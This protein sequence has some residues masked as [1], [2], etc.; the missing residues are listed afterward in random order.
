MSN[1]PFVP[2]VAVASMPLA[3]SSAAR[4]AARSSYPPQVG[5]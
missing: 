2:L 5:Q 4:L 1:C 3:F